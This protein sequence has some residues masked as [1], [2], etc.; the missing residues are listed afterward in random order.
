MRKIFTRSFVCCA[1]MVSALGCT[2]DDGPVTDAD[3]AS[4]AE[5]EGCGDAWLDLCRELECDPGDADWSGCGL[6]GWRD[7]K[8]IQTCELDTGWPGDDMAL[9]VPEEGEGL[10]LHYGPDFDD[11]EDVARYTL[12]PREE[13][14]DCYLVE[15]DNDEA[16]LVN[17]YS[18]RMRPQSHHMILWGVTEDPAEPLPRGLGTCRGS[19]T[20]GSSFYVGSQNLR[21][22][23][24]DLRNK[25]DEIEEHAARPLPANQL[26]SIDMH[27]LNRSTEPIVRESWIN[28][29]FANEEQIEKEAKAI[30]LVAPLISVPP[31]SVGTIVHGSCEA[32]KARTIRLLNGHFHE[33]GQRFSVYRKRAGEERELVYSSFDWSDPYIGYFTDSVTNPEPNR[34]FG[35]SGGTSGPIQLAAGD[36]LEWECEF[37]NPTNETVSFGELGADQ[38]CIVFGLYIDDEEDDAFNWNMAS[39][40]PG[41]PCVDSSVARDLNIDSL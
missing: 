31:N 25:P 20:L 32:P 9:C 38:M 2:G 39:I 37:D 35:I 36:A 19:A 7:K 11:A 1:G 21:I 23:I 28:I 26:F 22:D 24:P 5:A 27:Y 33:H 17:Q 34:E 10:Q 29:F 18:G 3:R 8:P 14:E 15:S 12:D 13:L 41:I 30:F 40:R 4:Y 16:Q 6:N